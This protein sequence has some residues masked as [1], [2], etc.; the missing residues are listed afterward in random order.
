M[1]YNVTIGFILDI[2]P[3]SGGKSLFLGWH[4][5]EAPRFTANVNDNENFHPEVNCQGSC[6][7][8]QCKFAYKL[9]SELAKV[10]VFS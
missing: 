4:G 8:A 10:L 5:S 3:I 1:M 9:L 6:Q 2:Y 7:R